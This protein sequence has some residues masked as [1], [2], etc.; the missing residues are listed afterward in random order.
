MAIYTKKDNSIGFQ[1]R[2]K[3]KLGIDKKQRPYLQFNSNSYI[4]GLLKGD[5]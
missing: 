3:N 4:I 5:L 2:K 1:R